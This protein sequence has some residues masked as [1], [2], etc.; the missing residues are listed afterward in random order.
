MSQRQAVEVEV[1]AAGAKQR[2]RLRGGLLQ[3]DGIAQLGRV[4]QAG[5]AV[6]VGRP[7][8]HTITCQAISEMPMTELKGSMGMSVSTKN[9][10]T[11]PEEKIANGMKEIL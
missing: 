11:D 4:V 2:E 8:N 10:M 9:I 7:Q 6:R 5:A 3:G 1:E